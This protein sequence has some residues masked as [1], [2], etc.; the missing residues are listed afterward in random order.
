VGSFPEEVTRAGVCGFNSQR[1]DHYV[2]LTR[3]FSVAIIR[4]ETLGEMIRAGGPFSCREAMLM[5]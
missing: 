5:N 2:D 1:D 4:A 3:S